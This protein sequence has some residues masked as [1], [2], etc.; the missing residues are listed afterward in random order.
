MNEMDII[1]IVVTLI[2]IGVVMFFVNKIPM[3]ETWLQIINAVAIIGT[4]FWLLAKF[5]PG[6]PNIFH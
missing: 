1:S 4:I 5:V 2:L 6:V 3:H